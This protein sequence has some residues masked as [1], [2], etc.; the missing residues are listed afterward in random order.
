MNEGGALESG[1]R[2]HMIKLIVS[3]SLTEIKTED[4]E[5]S[6]LAKLIKCLAQCGCC[7]LF[8][9]NTC[10]KAKGLPPE[11]SENSTPLEA[12][13]ELES[14]G[15]KS[16]GICDIVMITGEGDEREMH[17]RKMSGARRPHDRVRPISLSSLF[18]CMLFDDL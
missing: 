7:M 5:E 4:D 13:R 17:G 8:T 16:T 10:C 12:V 11:D 14:T 3:F 2:G 18:H 1:T 9:S 6:K 15:E